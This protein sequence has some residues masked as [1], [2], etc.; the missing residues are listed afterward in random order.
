[1]LAIAAGLEA[2]WSART[3]D[4]RLPPL[5]AVGGQDL[6]YLPGSEQEKM[7]PWSAAVLDALESIVGREV[8]DEVIARDLLE[9]LPLTHIPV[10]AS[11]MPL[12]SST[13]RRTSNGWCS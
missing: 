13:R 3:T 4:H 11:P 10:A 12:S 1:M 7:Q 6:G 2:V 9:V 5:F 8:I